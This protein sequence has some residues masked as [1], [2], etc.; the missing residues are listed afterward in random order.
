LYSSS[1]RIPEQSNIL[2]INIR[3]IREIGNTLAVNVDHA[4][5]ADGVQIVD[6][7]GRVSFDAED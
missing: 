5:D 6:G 1:S 7:D 2:I 3:I 4:R